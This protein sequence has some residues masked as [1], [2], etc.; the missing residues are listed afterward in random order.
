V[1]V[2]PEP[3]DVAVNRPVGRDCL[4]CFEGRSYTVP[5]GFAGQVVEVRGCAGTVQILAA[6][7]R[8]LREYPRGTEYPGPLRSPIPIDGGQ[9]SGLMAVSIPR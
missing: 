8:V 7:G 1:P 5:F 2:L 3:F 9:C 6:E 4:V